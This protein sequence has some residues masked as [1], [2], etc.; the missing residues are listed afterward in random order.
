MSASLTSSSVLLNDA[1]RLCGS[2]RMNPTVSEKKYP[3]RGGEGD[4]PDGESSVGEEHVFGQ[5]RRRRRTSSGASIFRRLY[6]LR[7]P[8]AG[9]APFL[10]VT[11]LSLPISRIF[12]LRW[13]ILVRIARRLR[14]DLCSPGPF[15][16]MP[17]NW[18]G[19]GGSTGGEAGEHVL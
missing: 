3:V 10:S 18:L 1:T 17:P 2:F 8:A 12:V 7:A 16:P 19:K 9:N 13:E 11:S 6:I 4:E 5:P 15:V 14:L